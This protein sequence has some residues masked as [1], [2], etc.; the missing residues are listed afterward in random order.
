MADQFWLNML[1][2]FNYLKNHLYTKWQYKY[3]FI[4][5]DSFKNNYSDKENK[6]IFKFAQKED[7]N[8]LKLNIFPILTDS[9]SNDYKE[10]NRIGET[11]FLCLLC[12][13]KEK[14]IHYTLVYKNIYK[15]PLI[16]TP[17]L[18]HLYNINDIYIGSA[19]TSPEYRGLMI[20]PNSILFLI[21][22]FKFSNYKRIILLIHS[23]TPGAIAFYNRLGFSQF[24]NSTRIPFYYKLINLCLKKIK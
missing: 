21:S 10:F 17:L 5:T 22:Y 6:F 9:Q 4:D 2:I 19:F 3:F 24:S 13:Y 15:S 7:Y 20:M 16:N 23:N 14:I 12:F 18:K 11:D 1:K 8:N